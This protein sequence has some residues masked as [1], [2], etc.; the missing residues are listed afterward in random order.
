MRDDRLGRTWAVSLD[1]F[2]I[3][4]TP[5]TQATYFEVTGKRP[6]TK[7]CDA[8]PVESVSWLDAVAFC[9][10]LSR[11][12]QLEQAYVID[13][14]GETAKV[15]PDSKGFRL[16]TEAE[17][18]YA[19]RAGTQSSRYGELD[20]IAWYAENSCDQLQPVGLKQPNTW[21]LHDMLGNVWEWCADQYDEEVYGLYRVF[22]GGGW[23]D[24][25][26]G[27]LASNRRRS[28]PTFKIEDLGFR[29][30]KSL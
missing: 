8:C 13:F 29:I 12:N 24:Q 28:H 2:D 1:P 30:A 6:S 9:N 27:C 19:C 23:A 7:I 21:G 20:E 16:P 14:A 25:E 11:R 4:I 15:I 18:E 26:R 10:S 22:R 5:V 3:A 17:W